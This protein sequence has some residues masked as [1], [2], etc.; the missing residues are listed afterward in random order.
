MTQKSR[1]QRR[2]EGGGTG[3][4]WLPRHSPVAPQ[5]E[6]TGNLNCQVGGGSSLTPGSGLREVWPPPGPSHQLSTNIHTTP[7]PRA[8]A[9]PKVGGHRSHLRWEGE[10]DGHRPLCLLKSV[11]EGVAATISSTHRNP[12]RSRGDPTPGPNP[13][14]ARATAPPPRAPPPTPPSGSQ[15]LGGPLRR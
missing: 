10:S 12:T 6:V 14:G 15:G 3:G 4:I 13:R 11:A 1:E 2:D 8:T 5:S 7:P 9:R